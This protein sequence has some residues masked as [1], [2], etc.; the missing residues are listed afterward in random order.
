[1]GKPAERTGMAANGTVTTRFQ[2][3]GP[4]VNPQ[5]MDS[6]SRSRERP[7]YSEIAEGAQPHLGPR[8]HLQEP[9][10]ASQTSAGPETFAG[11]AAPWDAKNPLTTNFTVASREHAGGAGGAGAADNSFR[12]GAGGANELRN[13]LKQ[14]SAYAISSAERAAPTQTALLNNSMHDG[15]AA[16]RGGFPT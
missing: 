13:S 2:S 3:V 4:H 7:L 15:F 16:E 10:F 12:Q 8:P 1:M 6:L 9:V 5:G 11:G 14:P